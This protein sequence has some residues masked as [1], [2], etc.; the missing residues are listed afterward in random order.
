MHEL[1]P[2]D[3]VG[4]KLRELAFV[5]VRKALIQLLAGHQLQHGVAEKFQPLVVRGRVRALAGNGAVGES[6]L[7]Q[8]AIGEAMA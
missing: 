4:A 3:P 2:V 6:F 7:Q 5:I 8:G 1:L